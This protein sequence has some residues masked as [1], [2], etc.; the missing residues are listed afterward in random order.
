MHQLLFDF[1]SKYI[2]LSEEEKET[3]VSLDIFKTVKK[4]TVLLEEGETFQDGF[5]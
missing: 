3:L 2:S 5:S 1:I 4:G